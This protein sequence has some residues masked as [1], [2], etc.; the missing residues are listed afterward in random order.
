MRPTFLAVEK[1]QWPVGASP[2][3][4]RAA[5]QKICGVWPRTPL[6]FSPGKSKQKLASVLSLDLRFLRFF[7]SW[8]HRDSIIPR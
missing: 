7:L 3:T 4:N 6:T 1:S 5:A 2:H 8:I